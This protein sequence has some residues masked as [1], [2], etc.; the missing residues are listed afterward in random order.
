MAS[1]ARS[2]PAQAPTAAALPILPF[3]ADDGAEHESGEQAHHGIGEIAE[4]E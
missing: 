3:G 2:A 1:N 4:R